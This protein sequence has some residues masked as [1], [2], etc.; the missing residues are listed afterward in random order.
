MPPKI[1]NF[2]NPTNVHKQDRFKI[3]FLLNYNI[4]ILLLY[5][6]IYILL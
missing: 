3:I 5:N 1:I 4:R 2:P 6:K